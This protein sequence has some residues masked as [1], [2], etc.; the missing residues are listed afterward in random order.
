MAFFSNE[1]RAKKLEYRINIMRARGE[2]ERWNLIRAAERKKRNLE[3]ENG[4]EK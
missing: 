1:V 3:K 2:Q 4:S